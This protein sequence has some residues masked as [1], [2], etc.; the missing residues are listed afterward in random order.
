MA[1]N[2]IT[3]IDVKTLPPF[4]RL[5]MTIGELPTSYLESMTYAEMLMWFCNFLQEKVLPTINNNADALQDVITYLEDL[6]LQDEVDHKLDEMAESGQLQEIIAD[7]L[8]SKAIFGFDSVAD[9][10]SATNLI[11]GSYAKTLGYYAIND[12][13][14]ATYKI[15]KITNADIVDNAKIIAIGDSD[16]IAELQIS[17]NIINPIMFGCKGDNIT[18]DSAN[19]LK[20]LK[21]YSDITINL[22]NKEYNLTTL[23]SF[24]FEKNTSLKNG[25]LNID[26]ILMRNADGLLQIEN[27]EINTVSLNDYGNNQKFII[28]S[29]TG[30]TGSLHLKN[31]KIISNKTNEHNNKVCLIYLKDY[32]D[33][34]IE[35]CI[36]KNNNQNTTIGGC[37]WLSDHNVTRNNVIIKN[38]DIYNTC[39]D[40]AVGI[41]DNVA[42]NYTEISNNIIESTGNP[43]YA[44]TLYGYLSKV[45]N[46]VNNTFISNTT[47][48]GIHDISNNN[49]VYVTNNILIHDASQ[50]IENN[51]SGIFSTYANVKANDNTFN[52]INC[53]SASYNIQPCV[54]SEIP[55]ISGW[56]YNY[57]VN[58]NYNAIGTVGKIYNTTMN[59][60]YYI[61]RYISNCNIKTTNAIL[62]GN[63]EAYNCNFN[64]TNCVKGYAT[65]NVIFKNCSG[66]KFAN[67]GVASNLII[68]NSS[69]DYGY[70]SVDNYVNDSG[71][72]NSA[73]TTGHVYFSSMN[74]SAISNISK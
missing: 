59:E 8:N 17:N 11:D 68:E 25:I 55:Y 1:I 40:E 14:S 34:V 38:N 37:I 33:V 16:L 36:L 32:K 31:S 61:Q 6:D 24:T 12:G 44:N 56:T 66:G 13:G 46:V 70:G 53:S 20:C 9:M 47:E 71:R 15:R 57:D 21:G 26:N 28:F 45:T 65:G 63:L 50:Q 5:I 72:L 22:L 10:K 30:D 23:E 18:D 4:K 29:E 2:E 19:F 41:Y 43:T 60:V 27:V 69:T 51:K 49:P 3:S 58:S 48:L 35:N 73:C 67:N 52:A 54:S 39:I 74:N 42:G 7:Y 62:G 64:I